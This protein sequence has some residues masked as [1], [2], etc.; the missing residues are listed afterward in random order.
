MPSEKQITLSHTGLSIM[1]QCPRCFW[2]QYHEKLRQ[3]EGFVS[4]LAS[5]FD[6]LLKRY[7][8]LFRQ[9]GTLPPF[10]RGFEGKLENPFQETYYFELNSRYRFKGKLDDCL[11]RPDGTHAPI[12]HK[13]SSSDPRGKEAHPSY[14]KQL[15][16]YSWLL[17]ENRKK[18]AGIGYLIYY[19]PEET[20]RFHEGVPMVTEIK[21]LLTDPEAARRRFLNGV[22]ILE[23]SLPL[24]GPECPF[25][26]WRE[27]MEELSAREL[28]S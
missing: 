23:A 14:Q 17:E 13:T 6:I 7:F 21:T 5:R 18:T 26:Q 1:E 19:Y 24:S 10:M 4:R 27:K 22:K 20:D 8:N 12:D 2:L 16:A 9:N 15:N 25:C 11:I 3:P 28:C